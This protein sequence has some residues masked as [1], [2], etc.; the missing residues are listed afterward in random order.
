MYSTR[1]THQQQQQQRG[2]SGDHPGRR[3]DRVSRVMTE[4]DIRRQQQQQGNDQGLVTLVP[5]DHQTS[6]EAQQIQQHA[7]LQPQIIQSL[8]AK[9]PMTNHHVSAQVQTS[10]VTHSPQGRPPDNWTTVQ[11][12]NQPQTSQE[13]KQRMQQHSVGDQAIGQQHSLTLITDEIRFSIIDEIIRRPGIWDCIREKTTGQSRKELFLEVANIVNHNHQILPP[14]LAEEIEK[15]WKNLKDTY[16]KTKKKLTYNDNGC[17][18]PPKWKF[19]NSMNFLDQM[20]DRAT[21]TRMAI[22]RITP[23]D[24]QISSS[25]MH[26]DNHTNS[27]HSPYCCQQ[28]SGGKRMYRAEENGT[29]SNANGT[30]TVDEFD[31]QM[32]FCRYLYHPLREIAYKDRSQAMKVQKAILDLVH[33]ARIAASE[34]SH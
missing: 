32:N 33:E 4:E 22:K 10:V 26:D 12:H 19:F 15:Q 24:E 6:A 17:V 9:Q 1:H 14:L 23:H 16:L 2:L 31:E 27:S 13:Q 34:Q 18:I 25:Q 5:V 8:D 3:M 29:S 30:G 11:N 20:R 7:I 21:P 28:N